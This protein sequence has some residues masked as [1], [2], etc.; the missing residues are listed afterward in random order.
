[1]SL[2]PGNYGGPYTGIGGGNTLGNQWQMDVG[3]GQMMDL[4]WLI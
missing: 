3:N 2:G 4:T 1:M